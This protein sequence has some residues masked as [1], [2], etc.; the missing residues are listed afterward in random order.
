[1]GWSE[2]MEKDLFKNILDTPSFYGNDMTTG[3]RD[4]HLWKKSNLRGPMQ[5]Q[6]VL[7][8]VLCITGLKGGRLCGVVP[9]FG[10]CSLVAAPVKAGK[11]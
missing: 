11:L 9:E 1:V 2:R 4:C 8:E 5:G 7:V 6:Q 3:V 10:S